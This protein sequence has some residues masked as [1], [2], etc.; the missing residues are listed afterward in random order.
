MTKNIAL[1]SVISR[2]HCPT[3][4]LHAVC[5]TGHWDGKSI[6][7][8]N[9]YKIGLILSTCGGKLSHIEQ[10]HINKSD[11]QISPIIKAL[12]KSK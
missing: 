2:T 8:F 6:D 3:L 4:G 12:W 10:I 1:R 11:Y 5:K 9:P 7:I